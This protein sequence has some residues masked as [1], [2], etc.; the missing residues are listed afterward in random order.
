METMYKKILAAHQPNLLPYLGFFDKMKSSDILVIR[1][2][3]LFI[4]KEYHRRNR[5]RINGNDNLNA[6]QSK[7]IGIP[8]FDKDDYI[9]NIK[10]KNSYMYKGK[11]WKD[12]ILKDIYVNYSKAPFFDK[13]YPELKEIFH[14]NHEYLLTLNME[15]IE[16]LCKVFNIKT[17]IVLAS[18]LGL[19]GDTYVKSDPS[20]DIALI[21]KALGYESYL[22]GSGGKNYLN[23]ESFSKR[24]I[25]V[26]FQ[27]YHHPTYKQQFPGFLPNMSAIDALFC[28]GKMPEEKMPAYEQS[29]KQEILNAPI[30]LNN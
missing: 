22:S 11:S 14:H 29:F 30:L 12:M 8:V 6:P 27:E 18:E 9:K 15:I 13:Y 17:K 19:K 25:E 23:M 21:C 28:L 3:V 2:E 5:I 16:Y 24:N 7:W 20:E 10:I 1:D 26:Q 4:E